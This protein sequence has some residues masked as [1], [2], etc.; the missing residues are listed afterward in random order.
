M[1]FKALGIGIARSLPDGEAHVVFDA[2]G[3]ATYVTPNPVRP[4]LNKDN[5]CQITWTV[6]EP[7]RHANPEFDVVFSNV[8]PCH[9]KDAYLLG[10]H[11][12]PSDDG[13]S[14]IWTWPMKDP[15]EEVIRLYDLFFIYGPKGTDLS[16]SRNTQTVS[17]RQIMSTDPTL[18]LPPKP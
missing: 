3:Q 7:P 12:E 4:I 9:M 13:R 18:I 16:R 11:S 1:T 10:L 5:K 6:A 14:W 15:G 17:L 8:V 2:G